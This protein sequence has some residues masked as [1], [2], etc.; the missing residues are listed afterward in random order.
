[1]E[2]VNTKITQLNKETEHKIDETQ[3]GN[4]KI[5]EELHDLEDKLD[6]YAKL[7]A[8]KEK[9]NKESVQVL[10]TKTEEL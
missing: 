7:I 4:E 5:V 2:L 1:M 6:S 10:I 8:T 9:L 3:E